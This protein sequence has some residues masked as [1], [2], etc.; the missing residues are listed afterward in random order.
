[1]AERRTTRGGESV[2]LIEHVR[3]GRERFLIKPNDDYGGR[4]LV[5]GARS[6]DAEWDGALAHALESDYVV[7]EALELHTEIFPV[8]D[9]VAWGFR[10]MYADTNPFLFRGRVEGAMVR[11]SGSPVVNVTSG[12]GEAGL[13]VLEGRLGG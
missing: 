1:M 5:F 9:D 8:F 10:P 3:R 7:Q 4:G 13:F 11:L 2:D 12:G 6:T